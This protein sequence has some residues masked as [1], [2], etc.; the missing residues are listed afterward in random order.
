MPILPSD[1]VLQEEAPGPAPAVPFRGRDF[2]AA[3]AFLH[4]THRTRPPHETLERIRPYFGTVGLTRLANLTGLDRIGVPVTLAVRPNGRVLSN[5]AGK[6][7]TSEAASVSAAMEAIEVYHAEN[8]RLAVLC[9]SYETLHTERATIPIDRLSH[10]RHAVF[11]ARLPE[12]WVLGWDLMQQ[13]EVAVPFAL[14][15]LI[16]GPGWP[17]AWWSFQGGSNGLASGNQ[18]LEAVC[19]G[20]FEV[21]ERDALACHMVAWEQLGRPIPRLR[22]ETIGSPLVQDLLARLIAA[23]VQPLL[24]DCAVDTG[25]PAYL[26]Y[27]YDQEQR[28]VGIFRGSGAHLDPEVAIVRALTEAIQSR[29]VYFAGSRDDLLRRGLLS[30]QVHDDRAIEFL[31]SVPPTVDAG[32]I[33]SEA[34]PA[35]EGDVH[36]VLQKLRSAGLDQAVVLD[37]THPGFDISV[38]RVIVPGLE[39]YRLESTAP[40]RRAL[41]FAA[42]RQQ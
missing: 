7:L 5:A 41:T 11:N 19:A 13:Q 36:L 27:L 31:E 34:T 6:G 16:A 1:R 3:K 39:G 12:R 38:V 9:Q 22:L 20:L 33:R 15:S 2:R 10:I 14:V 21:I 4:G 37:L 28:H 18:F 25:V 17:S 29:A 40:G 23:R 42:S 32:E 8:V 35:F 26:V 24:F 30:L